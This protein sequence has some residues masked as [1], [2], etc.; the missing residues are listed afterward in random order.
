MLEKVL[1]KRWYNRL[2]KIF[3]NRQPFSKSNFINE[4]LADDS[5]KKESIEVVYDYIFEYLP[6]TLDKNLYPSDDLINDYDIDD[7]D[8]GDIMIKVFKKLGLNFPNVNEQTMFYEQY[9]DK[10]TILQM[11]KFVE[12]FRRNRED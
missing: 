3:I 7:E 8:I 11:I 1:N 4:V 12:F 5:L 9:G 10:L 6:Q 2:N